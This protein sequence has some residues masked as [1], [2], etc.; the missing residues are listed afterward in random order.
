MEKEQNKNAGKEQ[1]KG[2][3]TYAI[4]QDFEEEI[5]SYVDKVNRETELPKQRIV[6]ELLIDAIRRAKKFCPNNSENSEI[7][8]DC[9]DNAL[10]TL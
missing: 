6:T 4:S 8:E 2:A 3:L 1:R 10:N 9:E 5:R 7:I